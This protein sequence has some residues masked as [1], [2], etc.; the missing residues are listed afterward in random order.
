MRGEMDSALVYL[1]RAGDLHR[2]AMG[3]ASY[4]TPTAL[5]YLTQA[6]AI[7]LR[8]GDLGAGLQAVERALADMAE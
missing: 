3:V 4:A 8:L 7:Y 1:Q 2:Q 5:D 6:R